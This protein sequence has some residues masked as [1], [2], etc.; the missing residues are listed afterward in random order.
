MKLVFLGT[1]AGVPSKERNVSSIALE[2]QQEQNS[3]WLFDCGEATQHQI[4][5]TPIKPRKVNKIFISHLH[6]DH[7]YGLPGFLSSRSFQNGETPLTIYGPAG[8]EAY[9]MT[10][11]RVSGTNLTYPLHI[12]EI[13]D[14]TIFEDDSVKVVAKK[15][16]HG[17]TS[18][19]FR[20]VEKDLPGQLLPEKLKA[21]GIEPGPIYQKIKQAETLTLD[22]GTVLY[23]K[24]FIGPDKPG[25]IVA[26]LG[27]TRYLPEVVGF[28]EGADVLVHEATFSG[29][30]D[31]L[32]HRYFHSTTKQAAT[33]A[34]EANVKQ[35][36]L[37]HISSRYQQVDTLLDEAK[38]IF[39]NSTIAYDFFEADIP[40]KQ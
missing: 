35:L 17:I 4:L 26:I 15:L 2:M 34:M 3:T 18:F 33:I 30:E 32:A 1:G 28:V 29:N 6:G 19:G 7:I 16:A 24:D 10:S 21:Y 9:V 25:R 5:R 12:N 37:T 8:I 27:D 39:K 23:R 40:S 36:F 11:L 22:N 13:T 38:Q 20:V 14:G 31:D